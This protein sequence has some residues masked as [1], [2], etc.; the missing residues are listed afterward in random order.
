MSMHQR[1][2]SI[3]CVI[4]CVAV[5]SQSSGRSQCGNKKNQTTDKTKSAAVLQFDTLHKVQQHLVSLEIKLPHTPVE[6]N[7]AEPPF[8]KEL[9]T[10]RKEWAQRRGKGS[11]I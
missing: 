3:D 2:I 4:H 1:L 7:N 10:Q 8:H 5:I 11:C 9:R 6:H